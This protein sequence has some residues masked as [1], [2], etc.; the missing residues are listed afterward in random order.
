[1]NKKLEYLKKVAKPK[2][3]SLAKMSDLQS[4]I[5]DATSYKMQEE[6]K[7]LTDLYETAISD[8]KN[9]ISSSQTYIENNEAFTG[10]SEDFWS[11]AEEI[12]GLYEEIETELENLGV[13]RS[14]ELDSMKDDIDVINY[15][16]ES[17]YFIYEAHF[18]WKELETVSN[19]QI[20]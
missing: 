2:K 13:E 6:E 3:V 11:L 4:M 12:T 10:L 9:A 18:D 5:N 7:H 19:I 15:D 16:K 1:M 14:P 20:Q 8:L 17:A